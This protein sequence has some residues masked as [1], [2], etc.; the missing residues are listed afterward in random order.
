M[1]G[2]TK[3]EKQMRQ[4]MRDT[5]GDETIRWLTTNDVALIEGSSKYTIRK[6]RQTGKISGWVHLDGVGVRI[7]PRDYVAC[8]EQRKGKPH[9]AMA[10]A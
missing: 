1:A 6:A 9:K 5:F 8:L 2:L 4:L 3:I 7:H 10:P